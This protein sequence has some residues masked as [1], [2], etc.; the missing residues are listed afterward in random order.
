MSAK[1]SDPIFPT[2][3]A[4]SAIVPIEE[5]PEMLRRWSENPAAF[6][7]IMVQIY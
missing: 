1:H 4:V 2:G 7:K 3:D 5:A 6:S